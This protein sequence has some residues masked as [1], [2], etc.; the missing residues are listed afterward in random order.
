MLASMENAV[1]VLSLLGF[2]FLNSLEKN[3]K[4]DFPK[5][6]LLFSGLTL[7]PLAYFK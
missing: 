6:F 7:K 5:F 3:L 1:F 2:H 4:F